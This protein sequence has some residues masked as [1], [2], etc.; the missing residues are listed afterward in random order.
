MV[1]LKR[2]VLIGLSFFV[3]SNVQA[4][5]SSVKEDVF[6][7]S[8]TCGDDSCYITFTPSDVEGVTITAWCSDDTYCDKFYNIVSNSYE[9]EIGLNNKKARISMSL[10]DNPYSG[11]AMYNVKKISLI[12]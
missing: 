4:M 1:N 5:P 12:N 7:E 6:L 11:T 9:S 3:I 8:F 10:E 2:F